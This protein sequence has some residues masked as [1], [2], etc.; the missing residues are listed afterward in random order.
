MPKI[1]SQLTIFDV[2]EASHIKE[3]TSQNTKRWEDLTP[4]DYVEVWWGNG[5]H[6]AGWITSMRNDH[7]V[8][9]EWEIQTDWME[10]NGEKESTRSWQEECKW[11]VRFS[12]LSAND[13]QWRWIR[14]DVDYTLRPTVDELRHVI[15]Q[16]LI[17]CQPSDC[18]KVAHLT[19]SLWPVSM[20][21][22]AN[23]LYNEV[24]IERWPDVRQYL[25]D[26]KLSR[27][28]LPKRVKTKI[29]EMVNL[30]ENERLAAL[31]TLHWDK[32]EHRSGWHLSL[33]SISGSFIRH[34]LAKTDDPKL[35]VELALLCGHWSGPC[36]DD[37]QT[38]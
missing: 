19:S 4:G 17:D 27:F 2:I 34:W 10:R 38:A 12:H 35:L 11:R 21:E 1:E 31:E 32:T 28:P 7:H 9:K 29:Q 36:E 23:R 20:R 24:L 30:P 8:E 22:D 5:L 33:S 18:V 15:R 14:H 3:A 6:F 37:E 16:N 25:A 13:R 26:K